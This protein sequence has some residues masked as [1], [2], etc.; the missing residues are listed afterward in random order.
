MPSRDPFFRGSSSVVSVSSAPCA[1]VDPDLLGSSVDG[2][3]REDV[4]MGRCE[5]AFV[6]E[7]LRDDVDPKLWEAVSAIYIRMIERRNGTRGRTWTV[8][9]S[10][11]GVGVVG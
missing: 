3:S 8:G 11:E 6:V 2:G 10:C 7:L 5:L 4:R 9:V 1:D